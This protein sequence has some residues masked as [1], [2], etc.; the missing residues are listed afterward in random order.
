MLADVA[1]HCPIIKKSYHG[2]F[3]RPPAQGYAVSAFNPLAAQ[4]C[5]VQTWVLFLSL[6]GNGGATPA[7]MTKVYQQCW[8]EWAG[9]GAHEGVPNN[10]ICGPKLADFSVH[11]FRVAL[12]WCMNGI[13]H[14]AI[15]AFLEPHHLHKVFNHPIISKLMCHFYLQCPLSC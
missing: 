15:S 1:Q 12:V 8:K 7:S 5:V 6:S 2:C 9:W 14:S 4:R 3:G 13:Y 11:L 10:A